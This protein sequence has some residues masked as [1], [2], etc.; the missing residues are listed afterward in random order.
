[1]CYQLPLMPFLSASQVVV[2]HEEIMRWCGSR[3]SCKQSKGGYDMS[4]RQLWPVPYSTL[5]TLAAVFL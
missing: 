2:T 3:S 4:P 1:M 5:G